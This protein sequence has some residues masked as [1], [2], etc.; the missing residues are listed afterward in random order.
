MSQD[1]VDIFDQ[2]WEKYDQWYEY[3]P[4][5]YRTELKAV[6]KLLPPKGV[7][8]EIGVGTGRFAAPLSVS[9]GV[10]PSFNML[11]LAK[12]RYIQV[13]QGK[14]ENLPFKKETFNFILIVVTI[15]FVQNPLRVFKEAHETLKEKGELVLG[16]IDKES[17]WGKYYEQKVPHSKFYQFAHFFSVPQILQMFNEAQLEFKKA[18]QALTS[19]PPH[20]SQVE[21]PK[22]GYGAGGFAVLK[23]VKK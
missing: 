1:K 11:R 15:C 23:A 13:V 4:L 7:G 19:P 21:E 2:Y 22:E 9:F 17:S 18:W 5:I 16:L 14:G 3:Q 12:K 20:I 10:D 8:L 6:K